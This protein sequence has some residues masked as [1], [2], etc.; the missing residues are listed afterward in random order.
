MFLMLARLEIVADE[1]EA[2]AVV[3]PPADK[4]DTRSVNRKAVQ[5]WGT[6][7]HLL[8]DLRGFPSGEIRALNS[9]NPPLDPNK[10]R[11]Q[12]GPRLTEFGG[13]SFFPNEDGSGPGAWHCRGNGARGKDIV[14]LV[15]FLA[16][17][18]ERRLA[19]DYLKRLTDR[20]V[21]MP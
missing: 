16:G 21:E 19:A 7:Y 17:G 18:C 14:E 20:L 12:T 1:P 13:V 15:Q 8:V 2:V 10:G 6:V 5:H 3:R 4:F 11:Q 9:A